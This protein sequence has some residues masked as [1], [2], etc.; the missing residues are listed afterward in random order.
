MLWGLVSRHLWT[1]LSEYMALR[2]LEKP[3]A[4]EE[5]EDSPLWQELFPK[6]E[7]IVAESSMVPVIPEES[8]VLMFQ[9]AEMDQLFRVFLASAKASARYQGGT[10]G[11]PVHLIR[12]SE[13]AKPKEDPALGWTRM[14]RGQVH[15]RPVSGSHMTLLQA[16]H[17]REVATV[18]D[19]ILRPQ[20]AAARKAPEAPSSEAGLSRSR[21]LT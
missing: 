5:K 17:V 1:Y 13:D 16:P 10:Y 2:R 9:Q 20:G 7:R 19:E 6:I 15:R 18:L 11:G 4:P 14:V 3:D 8:R 21:R 12:A